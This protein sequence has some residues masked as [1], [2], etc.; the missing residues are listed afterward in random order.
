VLG[1][2]FIVIMICAPEGIIGTLRA[3]LTRKDGDKGRYKGN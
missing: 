1:L 2:T 3:I